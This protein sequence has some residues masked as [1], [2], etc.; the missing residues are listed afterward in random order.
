MIE[1]EICVKPGYAVGLFITETPLRSGFFEYDEEREWL[2][3]Q[4]TRDPWYP[5]SMLQDI[6][7]KPEDII[8][9]DGIPVFRVIPVAGNSYF[10]S[11]ST[12]YIRQVY[13]DKIEIVVDQLDPVHETMIR[14]ASDPLPSEPVQYTGA[15]DPF[16]NYRLN[17]LAAPSPYACYFSLFLVK[18]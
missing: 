2:Y 9:P 1:E 4:L 7:V 17:A 18:L 14:F 11:I 10:P 3:E 5:T 15:R 13:G 8:D 12:E 6:I 16:W